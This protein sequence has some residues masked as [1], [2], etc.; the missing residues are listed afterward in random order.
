MGHIQNESFYSSYLGDQIDA[1]LG[2]MAQANPLPSGTDW[3]AFIDDCRA[4]QTAAETAQTAAEAAAAAAQTWSSNPPY[5]DPTTGD[6]FVYNTQTQQ[7]VNS[8]VHAQGPKGD[9]GATGAAG[10][11]GVSPGVSFT[12]LPNG[13]R[14]TVTD[15]AHPGGQSVDILNGNGA[16]DMVSSTYDP[17]GTVAAAGGIPA[18]VA[19]HAP[20]GGVTSFN[21]RTGAVTPTAGDYTAP[22]VGA[23]AQ[24]QIAG[25]ESTTTASQ[26]YAIGA[27]FVYNGTLYRATAAIA[28]GDT[29]DPTA[30]TGNCEAVRLADELNTL[31]QEVTLGLAGKVPVIGKGINFLDNWYFPNPV[32]QRGISLNTAVSAANPVIY[33]FIDRWKITDGSATLTASGVMLNGTMVQILENAIG[34]TV[35]ASALLSDGTIITPT[36]DDSTRIF[37]LTASNKTIVAVKLELGD[38]QTLARNISTDA[39][40]NWVL[41][42]P[43]PNFVEELAKCQ[44]YFIRVCSGSGRFAMTGAIDMAYGGPG[45]AIFFVPLPVSMYKTPAI[46]GF[47]NGGWYTATDGSHSWQMTFTPFLAQSGI[48]LIGVPANQFTQSNGTISWI[49]AGV[50]D[51][52]ADL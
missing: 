42:D 15:A 44:R 2:A 24:S 22:M 52:S 11:D 13:S 43:P 4:A 26:A 37:T 3:V 45:Q 34:A 29:I 6:W 35:T 20:A 18:Y 19:N 33:N 39:N 51:F 8:G 36:Y 27:Y 30:S 12:P 41:N 23:A 49:S 40:P 32:N 47:D 16:G 5:I 28:Q 17:Q 1:L 38:T 46:T 48:Y 25:V 50:C 21:S 7:F 14:M 31:S 9:T 10:A